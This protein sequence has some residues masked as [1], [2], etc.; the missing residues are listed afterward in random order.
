MAEGSSK[1]IKKAVKSWFRK[2]GTKIETISNPRAEFLFKVK[3]QRFFFTVVRPNEQKY[4]QVESQVMI[5]PQHLKVLN[6]EKMREFQV[7][8]LKASFAQG[9][10][11]GFIQPRPGQ[12]G[13]KPPG[14]G[15]VVSDRIYD[16]GFGEDRLWQVLRRVH[17]TVDM[18]IALLNEITGQTGVRPP[19]EPTDTGPTYYT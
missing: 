15:F 3:F 5:S 2:E 11:M 17:G 16:D 6:A 10:N 13:P 8:A 14:P 12:P 7:Q 4:I 9:V 18:A 1:R 19:K